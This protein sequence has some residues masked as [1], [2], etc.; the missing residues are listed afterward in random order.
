MFVFELSYFKFETFFDAFVTGLKFGLIVFINL[1]RFRKF[2]TIFFHAYEYI[3]YTRT[4]IQT[5]T[6]IC[7]KYSNP[8]DWGQIKGTLKIYDF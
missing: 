3:L 1:L 2:V 7:S 6:Y 5:P 4:D 8:E